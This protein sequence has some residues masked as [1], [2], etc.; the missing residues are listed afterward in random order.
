MTN[1]LP[2]CLANWWITYLL[3]VQCFKNVCIQHSYAQ[4]ELFTF[5]VRQGN[6]QLANQNAAKIASGIKDWLKVC[7]TIVADSVIYKNIPSQ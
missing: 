5:T 1:L 4:N 3:I 2:S 7:I 6:L